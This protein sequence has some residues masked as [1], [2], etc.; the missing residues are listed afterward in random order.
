MNT[1]TCFENPPAS[2]HHAMDERVIIHNNLY[3]PFH[4]SWA[5][6]TPITYQRKRQKHPEHYPKCLFLHQRLLQPGEFVGQI[7]LHILRIPDT[8]CVLSIDHMNY[9]FGCE[10]KLDRY[11]LSENY[12]RVYTT[13]HILDHGECYKKY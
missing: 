11:Q 3:E 8:W 9:D 7:M 1:H 13:K 2:L 4:G 6:Y 5:V 10:M 12:P